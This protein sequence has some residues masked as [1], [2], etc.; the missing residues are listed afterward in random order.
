MPRQLATAQACLAPDWRYQRACA[1]L[2][3]GRP[4]SRIDDDPSVHRLHRFLALRQ[5]ATSRFA[6][7][8]LKSRMP[9]IAAA[10]EFR[11][12]RS[13][14]AWLLEAY[15]LTTAPLEEVAARFGLSVEAIRAYHDGFYD[16]GSRLQQSEYIVHVAILGSTRNNLEAGVKLAAYLQ[17]ADALAALL[18]PSSW[19]GDDGFSAAFAAAQDSLTSVLRLVA[20][21]RQDPPDG[22]AQQMLMQSSRQRAAEPRSAPLNAYE[23]NVQA[24]L[25]TLQYACGRPDPSK[26]PPGAEKYI[27]SPYDLKY[28]EWVALYR[29]EPLSELDE[30]LAKQPACPIRAGDAAPAQ[31]DDAAAPTQADHALPGGTADG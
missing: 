31:Q 29:G 16:V 26:L 12:R 28:S 23:E 9:A 18:R 7:A 1:L 15:L 22:L 20:L 4:P 11:E 8:R 30:L 3:A 21:L 2:A 10:V 17:S 24:V 14:A 13:S 25:D 6:V 5:G 27:D 19:V